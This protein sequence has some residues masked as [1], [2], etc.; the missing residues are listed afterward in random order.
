MI[1]NI[2]S[3][4]RL[5]IWEQVNAFSKVQRE[6]LFAHLF[7]IIQFLHEACML[8]HTR[9]TECLRLR[10]NS[11]YKVIIRDGCARDLALDL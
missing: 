1:Q 8:L 7:S 5:C 3:R 2:Q 4:N 6:G 10:A 11:I 9:D